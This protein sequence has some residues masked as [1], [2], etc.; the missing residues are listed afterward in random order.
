MLHID[1]AGYD[2]RVLQTIDLRMHRPLVVMYEHRHLTAVE[3]ESAR[4]LLVQS[5]YRL[6]TFA[7]DTLAVRVRR[8]V[9]LVDQL[10]A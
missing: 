9:V 6:M 7:A 1:A 10:G 5:G 2:Y 8:E 4:R 3:R